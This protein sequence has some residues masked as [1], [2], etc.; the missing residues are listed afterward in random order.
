MALKDGEVVAGL[1][2]QSPDISARGV[3][4]TWNTCLAVDDADAATEAVERVGGQVLM[5]PSE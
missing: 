2:R 4:P 3:P 5:P 1:Y